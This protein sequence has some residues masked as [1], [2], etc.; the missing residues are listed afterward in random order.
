MKIAPILDAFSLR[1]NSG[2]AADVVLL[3]TGQHYDKT[4]SGDFF[5]DLGLPDPDINLGIGAG[6]HAEQTGKAMI[7]FEKACMAEHPDCVIV[8]GD[9]NSTLACSITAKKLGIPVAH[10]EA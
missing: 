3:H 7:G 2:Q 4:M 6:S 1:R 8:V 5:S 9:V 10:V